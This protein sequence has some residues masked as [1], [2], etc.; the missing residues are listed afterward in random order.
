MGIGDGVA[1]PDCGSRIVME[2]HVH[3][4]QG[5]GGKVHFLTIDCQTSRSFITGFQQQ[6]PRTTGG[7]INRGV[8]G[9]LLIDSNDLGQNSGDLRRRVELTLGLTRFC[10]EVTHQVLVGIAQQIISIGTIRG[11]VQSLENSNQL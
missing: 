3:A 1:L 8:L 4:G 5:A 6:R 10:G 11:Q 7:V 9:C 2:N